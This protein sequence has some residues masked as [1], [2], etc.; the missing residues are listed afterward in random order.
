MFI[1]WRVVGG[2]F[3]GMVL[4]NGIFTYG[5]TVIVNHVR[6]DF[7]ATLE[8]VM[9]SPALGTLCGLLV[10]PLI[11]TLIDK[12]SVRALMTLGCFITAAGLYAISQTQTILAFNIAFALTMALSMAMM[13]SM[14]GSAVVARWFTRNRGKAL[15]IASMGTSLG[16]VIIPSL[17]TY[18]VESDGWRGALQNTALV[19]LLIVAP[20]V[21]LTVRNRPQDLGL[22]PEGDSEP[23]PQPAGAAAGALGMADIV[24]TRPFWLIGFSMGMVFAAFSSMLANLGPYAERLGVSETEISTMIAVLSIGGLVGKYLFGTAADKV[25]LKLGLWMAH[26]LLLTALSLLLLEPPYWVMLVAA[27]CFGLSTGGLLPVWN[28]M[29]AKVYG[30]DSFGRTM[31]AMSPLITVCIVP[32]YAVVGRLVDNSGDYHLALLV[33]I[34]AV[35]AAAVLLLPLRIAKQ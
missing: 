22:H 25:N 2:A 32:G 21:W 29:V 20:I 10:A 9:Y 34:A 17:L 1:G 35:I 15:G 6:T 30:I 5:F 19:T 31:G 26:G 27:V 3:V 11:G 33:C 23:P 7:D 18:W 16:G 28:S 24:R 13:S 12:S 4:A 14:T 8:Q